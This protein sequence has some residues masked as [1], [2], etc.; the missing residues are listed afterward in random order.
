VGQR[1]GS[2]GLTDGGDDR[3]GEVEGA[4]EAPL[5]AG[6]V[7]LGLQRQALQLAVVV[8]GEAVLSAEL[9]PL[10]SQQPLPAALRLGFQRIENSGTHQQVGQDAQN[11]RRRARALLPH[12]GSPAPSAGFRAPRRLQLHLRRARLTA[13]GGL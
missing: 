7:R 1:G 10:P 2:G 9:A 13:G 4:C 11:E 6:A 12:R 8:G 5:A 3:D